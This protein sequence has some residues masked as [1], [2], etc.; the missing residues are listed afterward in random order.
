MVASWHCLVVSQNSLTT[1]IHTILSF[2]AMQTD[3]AVR[4]ACRPQLGAFSIL[5]KDLRLHF[6]DWRLRIGIGAQDFGMEV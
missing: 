5:I 6:K 3:C 4:V 1:H 2:E